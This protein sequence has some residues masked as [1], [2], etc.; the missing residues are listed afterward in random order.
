MIIITS[1]R[2]PPLGVQLVVDYF[3]AFS[4]LAC[5]YEAENTHIA[6][7]YSRLSEEIRMESESGR[8]DRIHEIE[9]TGT[10]DI[11][12]QSGG[13]AIR[14]TRSKGVSGICESADC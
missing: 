9:R 2:A 11:F 13:C 8:I 7:H 14:R 12:Y 4:N 1:C 5:L 10:I 6:Y 3:I